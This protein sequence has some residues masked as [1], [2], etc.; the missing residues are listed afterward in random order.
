MSRPTYLPNITVQVDV[1]QTTETVATLAR[2]VDPEFVAQTIAEPMREMWVSRLKG[3]GT[4]KR[5]W[6]S[7]GFWEAAARDTIAIVQGTQITLRCQKVGVR[8]RALGG[9]ITPKNA[10]ALTI[11][12]SPV[13]YGR[14]ASEFPGLFL[15]R[16]K[17]GSYLVQQGES[18]T[19]SGNT[20][21]GTG[22]GGNRKRRQRA[23]LNFL[24]KLASSVTQE[25]DPRVIP[26]ND[27]LTE[28]AMAAITKELAT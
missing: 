15:L 21:Q 18:V 5:G 8:Q 11:P 27:E 25:A 9:T 28:V 24:F 26:S 12:I 14:R 10:K 19:S 20:R 6:P 3:L 4:N 17:R 2:K 22:L 23:G 1:S 16:T 13:S 7:T